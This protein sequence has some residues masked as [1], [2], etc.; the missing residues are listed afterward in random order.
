MKIGPHWRIFRD[1]FLGDRELYGSLLVAAI[2]LVGDIVTPAGWWKPVFRTIALLIL[3]GGVGLSIYS[4]Y[5]SSLLLHQ[6]KPIPLTPVV[7]TTRHIHLFHSIPV[8]LVLG[9]GLALGTFVPI[10]VYNWERD[11]ETYYPVLHLYRLESRL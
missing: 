2:L 1:Q 11:Q 6:K 7:G 9:V 4:H 10:T 5:R 3:V 8:S